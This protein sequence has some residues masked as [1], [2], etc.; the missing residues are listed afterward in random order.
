M[1]WLHELEIVKTPDE[2]WKDLRMGVDFIGE[3]PQAR[4][5]DIHALG[6]LYNIKEDSIKLRQYCYLNEVDKFDYGF[7]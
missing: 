1:V 2:F 7:F 4:I 3:M 5:P 6:K